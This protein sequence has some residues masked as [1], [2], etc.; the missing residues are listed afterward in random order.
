MSFDF[1]VKTLMVSDDI[2]V[3][4]YF[5]IILKCRWAFP[6]FGMTYLTFVCK[7]YVSYLFKCGMIDNTPEKGFF[8]N[9][10]LLTIDFCS[11]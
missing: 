9:V 2:A 8:G 5:D 11:D 3:P 6:C 10:L 4:C 7:T 1:F